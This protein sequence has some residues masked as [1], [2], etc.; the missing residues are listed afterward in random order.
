MDKC[1]HQSL[2]VKMCRKMRRRMNSGIKEPVEEMLLQIQ[3][4]VK[5]LK[6][7]IRAITTIIDFKIKRKI[8]FFYFEK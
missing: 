5:E 2:E 8:E 4:L 1:K 7:V 3:I 6:M